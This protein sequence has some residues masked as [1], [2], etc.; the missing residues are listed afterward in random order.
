MLPSEL[1]RLRFDISRSFRY[2][3]L[4]GLRIRS[5]LLCNILRGDASSVQPQCFLLSLPVCLEP[6]GIRAESG[7]R[8]AV[9]GDFIPVPTFITLAV[10]EVP[11]DCLGQLEP[12]SGH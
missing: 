11:F 10:F 12:Q 3:A 2:P 8:A 5:Q 9:S 7:I 4:H 1:P 6:T